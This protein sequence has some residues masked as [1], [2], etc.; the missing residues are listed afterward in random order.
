MFILELLGVHGL[1]G[2]LE[3]FSPCPTSSKGRL[4][5]DTLGSSV[6]VG[7]QG[8]PWEPVATEA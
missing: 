2:S 4:G 7:G 1:K 8:S 6:T 5:Q 3:S